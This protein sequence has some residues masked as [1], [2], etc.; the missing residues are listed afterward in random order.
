MFGVQCNIS[1]ADLVWTNK[2]ILLLAKGRDVYF[3]ISVTKIQAFGTF[4]FL[5][6][7]Y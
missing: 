5:R 2:Q 1:A 6:K 7:T 4:A 3:R